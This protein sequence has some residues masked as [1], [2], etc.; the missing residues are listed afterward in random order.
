MLYLEFAGD[1]FSLLVYVAF[2]AVILTYYGVPLHIIRQLYMTF[3]AFQRRV[4]EVRR[5][6]LAT[7]DMNTR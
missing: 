6:R 7:R 1:I 3:V 5:Y 4:D 2:F